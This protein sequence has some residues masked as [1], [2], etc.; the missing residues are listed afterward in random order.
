MWGILFISE[1]KQYYYVILNNAAQCC[2]IK[3]K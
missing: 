3:Y 2:R 1:N